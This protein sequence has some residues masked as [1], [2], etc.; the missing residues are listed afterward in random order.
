MRRLAHLLVPIVAIIAASEISVEAG[1]APIGTEFQVNT[2]TTSSQVNA[3]VAMSAAGDLVVVW[4]SRQDGDSWGIF[5][6]MLDSGGS[7]VGAEFQVNTHTIFQQYRPAVATNA[8]GGFAVVWGSSLQ[9]GSSSGVFGQMFNSA[10]S[11]VGT[12]FQVNTYTTNAQRSPAVGMNEAGDFVV[13]WSSL[14]QD[15]HSWGI[16]GQMFDSAGSPV[17]AEFQVNTYTTD[18]Q[19]VPVVGMNAA[20]DFVVAWNSLDQDGDSWGV[21]GQMF[22][23]AGS[24]VGAEFQVNTCTTSIQLSPAVGM[25][26]A[27]DFVATWYGIGQDG[28]S[29]GVFGQM[30][31]GGGSPIGA[32]F[33]ANT[34]TTGYPFVPALGVNPAGGFVVVW[35]SLQDGSGHGI[36]GQ[37]FDS[38]GSPVAS[39]I[40]VNTYTLGP[41]TRPVV[42]VNEAGD[43]VVAWQSF[44]QDGSAFGVFAQRGVTNGPSLSAPAPAGTVDCS[45][46]GLNRPVI[47]W[48]PGGYDRFRVFMGSSPGFENGTRMTSGNLNAVAASWIPSKGRWKSACNKALTQAADP[49]NPLMYIAVE[50]EDLDLSRG[51]P[52]RYLLSFPV[53]TSV[54]P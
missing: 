52:L 6:Q 7:P 35:A 31:D 47:T 24:P 15:G 41:Q 14:A 23:S 27:G 5:G 50:G 54:K 49:N 19:Y 16:F 28:N 40:Q 53:C 1:A 4:E 17:G 12:E 18:H 2:Y 37:M 3:T 13:V 48:D 30:F 9:D 26:K 39:E 34:Y 43:F 33:Q 46:A 42:G 20:G 38:G 51:D 25:N 10:G 21:F 8:T 45:E 29:W 44:G 11:P 32:E 36:F 22:D